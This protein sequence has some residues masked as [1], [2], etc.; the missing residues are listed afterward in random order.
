M[1]KSKTKRSTVERRKKIL[2]LLDTNGQVFVHEL[3]EQFKVSEVT[4]RNDL[5]LFESKKLLIRARGGA[6]KFENSV[7]TDYRISEKDKI[8]YAEKIKIGIK[9]AS[10][11]NEGETIIL[12]SGTTTMEVAR[13]LDSK[14]SINVITNALNIANQLIN[15][16]NI[17][18]IVPGGTLR[19]NS[20]SLV[21][22]LAEKNLR[23]FY[24]DK[25]FLGVD[26]FDCSLGA[27]TPNIEEAS[28]NQI[29][30]E[31]AKDVILVAD[32]SKFNRRSLAFI[33]S[34][35]KIDI[36]V[37]DD[38]ISSENQKQLEE[39]GVKVIIA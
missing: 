13:H 30:I 25:L 39:L 35:Q 9:A 20:H 24:V 10:L 8:H 22:P 7:S 19:K 21:G 17:N 34:T 29:M 18:I 12:D 15:S 14:N 23:N 33:C 5:E 28:L 26:G 1:D 38:K 11:V 16:L 4:I 37:T 32:S 31:I 3:S 6:M 2:N 36:I 27:F